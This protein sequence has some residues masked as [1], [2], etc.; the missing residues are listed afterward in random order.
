MYK[1]QYVN[2]RELIL[3]AFKRYCEDVRSGA[4][5]DPKEHTRYMA[6]GEYE[7]LLKMLGKK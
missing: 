6:E 4:Y 7:K 5:P 2:L 1:R 3:D